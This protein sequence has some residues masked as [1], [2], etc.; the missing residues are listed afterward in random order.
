MKATLAALW[1]VD[2]TLVDTAELHFQAWVDLCREL[3]RSFTR[4]EFTATFGRRN[5][6]IIR[7]LFGWG[8]SDTQLTKLGER[9]E[10]LYRAEVQKGVALLPGVKNLLEG[11]HLGGF[12]QAIG[13]SAPRHNV[14]LI[15]RLT[16]TAPFMGAVVSMEDTQRGKPD[17]EVF[18]VAA[19]RVRVPTKCC[20]VLED[21]P[22]GIQA[23]KAAGMKCIAVNFV[24]HHGKQVLLDAGADLVVQ[25]LQSVSAEIVRQL[26]E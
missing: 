6:E 10:N 25:D 12:K 3:G 2:G 17:P 24:G 26:L 11:L 1:D 13:S 20:L 8:Y 9:K 4:A 7:E 15:L 21:S 5:P 16:N 22:A 14:D 18:L 23:A 19:D